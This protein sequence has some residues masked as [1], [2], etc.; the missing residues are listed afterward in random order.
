M[1]G[2]MGILRIGQFSESFLPIVDGVSRVVFNYASRLAAKGHECYVITPM[3]DTGFR[4]GFPFEIVDYISIT[5]PRTP[6][7][8]MGLATLDKHY[9]E[10]IEMIDFDVIHAHTPFT[11]GMEAIRLSKK[12]R[13][14]IIGTFHSKYYEDFY[15]VTGA[16]LI[17]NLGVKYVV[18]FYEKCDEVW[19]V[20]KHSAATLREYGYGGDIVIVENGTVLSEPL[21]E[22]ERAARETFE[23]AGEKSILLYVGQLDWKKNILLILEASECLHREGIDF[24][25]VIAGK[26]PD[27]DNI[28]KKVCEMGLD[29]ITTFTGH[30]TDM[31][32]LNGLYQCAD[33]LVFPSTYDTSSLV[34]REAAAMHTPS[35]VVRGSA[36][37]EVVRDGFNGYVSEN[38]P[39]SLAGTIVQA[40]RDKARNSCVGKE[41]RNTIP[42]DWDEVIDGVIGRYLNLYDK[43]KSKGRSDN[44]G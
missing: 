31:S 7:Y 33:L 24:R 39:E 38:T 36:P 1:A 34:M 5:V 40:L 19:T 23:L 42:V 20:S 35:V 29:G 18:K 15:K 30:I 32:L 9:K 14:P 25:L 26:G 43:Y 6:Q 11:A 28:R 13:C 3:A 17:A 16:E 12:H 44:N 21:P 4:G 37:A 41:A 27:E 22:D 10:R 8:R 2:A